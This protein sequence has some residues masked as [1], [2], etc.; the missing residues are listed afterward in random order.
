MKTGRPKRLLAL[1]ED[2][3]AHLQR[4]ITSPSLRQGLGTRA[5][6]ILLS[7]RGLSNAAIAERLGVT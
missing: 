7:H 4:L 6:L 3:V 2:D 1:T 5:R